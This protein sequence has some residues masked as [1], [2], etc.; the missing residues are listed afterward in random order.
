MALRV[1]SFRSRSCNY[2]YA[3]KSA[4]LKDYK[5]G[6]SPSILLV[7]SADDCS[8]LTVSKVNVWLAVSAATDCCSVSGV[9]SLRCARFTCVLRFPFCVKAIEQKQ[10]L[11]GRSP[12]CFLMCV[13]SAFFWLKAR[14]HSV[15]TN[16]RSP[17]TAI[18]SQ[19]TY[20][21]RL[22]FRQVYKK[23][24]VTMTLLSSTFFP[25]FKDLFIQ[26]WHLKYL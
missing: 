20:L 13:S 16:G 11:W 6:I 1:A 14:P 26:L 19:C 2:M 22:R 9:T 18:R 23:K 5:N 21:N 17:V 25:Q 15:Q 12:R 8:P 7:L 24:S 10:H 3:I 4:D